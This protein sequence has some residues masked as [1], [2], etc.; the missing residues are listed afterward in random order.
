MAYKKHISKSTRQTKEIAKSFAKSLSGTS[1]LLLKGDLGSGKTTFIQ[2]L[3][4]G[5]GIKKRIT[6]PTFILVR[7]YSIEEKN[8]PSALW[9]IDLYRLNSK[10]DVENL[11]IQDALKESS[12]VA[13]EWPEKVGNLADGFKGKVFKIKFKPISF[14]EREITINA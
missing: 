6:S 3:A 4:Q 12:V 5:L 13:I 8:L 1:L 14:N 11:G 9:H 2:G 10:K 7:K